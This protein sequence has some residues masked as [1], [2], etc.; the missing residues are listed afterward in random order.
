MSSQN[1]CADFDHALDQGLRDMAETLPKEARIHVAEC[2]RCRALLHSLDEQPV[3]IV[4]E[5]P[6]KQLQETLL[7]D[8]RPVRPLA[9]NWVFLA[10]FAAIFAVLL[11]I[12]ILRLGTFGWEALTSL[13]RAT[14]VTSLAASAVLLAFAAVVQMVPAARLR[15]PP[16]FGL[17]SV[18]V[19][20]GIAFASVFRYEHDPHFIRVGM[21]C[22]TAGISYAI[23]AAILFALVLRRG[24]VLRPALS[25]ATCGMLAG[26]IGTS[27]LEMHCPILDVWHILTWHLGVCVLGAA[28]GLLV[29]FLGSRITS[30]SVHSNAK[31]RAT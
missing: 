4:P 21:S 10:L 22:L 18:L 7:Q 30:F 13:Q 17:M 29:G 23:L 27:V 14:V 11:G 26:L 3:F 6:I 16:A 2:Q 20:L 9:P 12:G 24:L 25:G 19:V 8:L 31:T 15:F 28:C 5:L 1:H